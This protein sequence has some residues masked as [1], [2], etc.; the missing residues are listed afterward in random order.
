MEIEEDL[1][2]EQSSH[3]KK[4]KELPSPLDR[5][6]FRSNA[7]TVRE[8]RQS[9]S[10]EK[11]LRRKQDDRDRASRE[12]PNREFRQSRDTDSH[13]RTER[14]ARRSRERVS[15]WS[16]DHDE[17]QRRSREPR[18]SRFDRSRS[19]SKSRDQSRRR[20]DGVLVWQ[21]QEVGYDHFKV[22]SF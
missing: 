5:G 10:G 11:D 8:S 14:D 7:S 21:D 3:D 4:M 12:H 17:A 2:T 16:R 13:L 15:R 18:T 1:P 9:P 19:R 6:N 20:I 22:I